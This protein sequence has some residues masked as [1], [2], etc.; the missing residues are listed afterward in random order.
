MAERRGRMPEDRLLAIVRAEIRQC[1]GY[2]GD[3]LSEDRRE[4]LEYY[5]AEPFG[6]ETDG[7]SQVVSP[8]VQD[9]IESV[10]PDFMEIFAS[11]DE[12]VRFEPRSREDEKFAL[13]A[14]DYVNYIWRT[15]ND[16]F[17]LS[18]DWI[19]DALL[20][21]LG[22]LKVYWDRTPRKTKKTLSGLSTWTVQQLAEDED[23]EIVAYSERA[24]EEAEAEY[25]PDGV[26]HD[27]TIEVREDD[28][29]V[30]VVGVPPEEF[31]FSRQ[32][33]SLDEARLVAHRVRMTASDL[34]EMGHDEDLIES[35]PSHDSAEI[36]EERVTRFTVD[37][38]GNW[39]GQAGQ[40]EDRSTRPIWVYECYL[41]VDYDGD[42]IAELRQVTVAGPGATLLPDPET[43]EKAV[44]VEERPFVT[45]TPIRMPHRTIGRSLADLVRSIQLLKS[46]V[47]RQLMDN[48]YAIN[49]AR[50]LINERVN[51]DD[52]LVQRPGG[53]VRVDGVGPVGDAMVP[54]QTQSLGS[55]AYPLL[56]YLDGVKESSTGVTRYN[57]GLDAD[58]LNK[59]AT[60]IN[61]I[62][63]RAQQRILLI[64]RL[65]SETGFRDLFGKILRLV[66]SHQ[67]RARVM[68]LRNDFVEM[69]PRG[70]NPSMDV[71]VNVA[72]G[73]GTREQ[74]A[75][76]ARLLLDVQRQIIEYQGGADGPLVTLGNVYGALKKLVPAL[77]MK[78]VEAVFTDPANAPP[79]PPRPDPKMAEAQGKLQIEQARVQLQ[80][81]ADQGK[82]ALEQ[83]KA[84]SDIEIARM[85]AQ[86]DIQVQR[87]KMLAEIELRRMEM[88]E[89]LA[90]R[91]E[92]AGA[93]MVIRSQE[94]RS[95][96]SKPEGVT[97][98]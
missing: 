97:R 26:L 91:R 25:V 60:G 19:K 21:R 92:E 27:L 68:R 69:D 78:D 3:Q 59:T 12:V 74:Q 96:A 93:M 4:A 43:G 75:T 65:F 16:G 7:R 24:P 58:S 48:M 77:G 8:D 64:A 47:W 39:G 2:L 61:Q 52:W 14:T 54:V 82:M 31:L 33:A 45:I 56:E 70:W 86:A 83:Q 84:Q 63:G 85:K 40:S 42:G 5:Y 29:R 13:Q 9:T 30:R 49:N 80:A 87:E 28:G 17:G 98:Q 32:A 95:R 72:L 23:V 81:Q 10:M 89:T 11:G 46:T 57:Q 38:S 94:A 22:V 15:D 88:A 18:Y 67:D 53:A 6:N 37:G 62:L 73:R 79:A 66:V 55:Y 35:I 34:I 36:S 76:M 51:M 1:E 71:V 50:A 20:Q 90:I 41:R 44:E